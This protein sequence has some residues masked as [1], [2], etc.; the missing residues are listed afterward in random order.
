[1]SREADV[2]DLPGLPCGDER[3]DRA[4][5]REDALGVGFADDLVD[6]HEIDPV[7]LEALERLV[8]LPRRGLA[9]A[10][11]DLRHEEDA[12]AVAVAERPPHPPLALAVVVVP[13]V[14]EERDAAVHGGADDPD[15]L[16]VGG[17]DAHVASAEADDRH[18]SPVRPSR[19]MGSDGLLGPAPSLP[20]VA[21]SPHPTTGASVAAAAR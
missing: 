19:R 16:L 18:R 17:L 6:L 11:V 4:P 9:L 13:A 7:G 10:A 3:L 5:R 21:P 15:A 14:V 8:D 12:V 1:M 2:A 20:I